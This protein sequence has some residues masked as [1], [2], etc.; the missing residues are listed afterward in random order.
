MISRMELGGGARMP[1][2]TWAAAAE[3]VDLRLVVDLVDARPDVLPRDGSLAVRC[4]RTIAREARIG[5]WTA[6]TEI[7]SQV[8]HQAIE[9]V[10]TRKSGSVVVVHAWDVVTRVA[11]SLEVLRSSVARERTGSDGIAVGGLIVVPS[12]PGNRRRM[13]EEHAILERETPALAAHWYAAIRNAHRPMPTDLGV[14]W[15]DRQG[16]RLVPAP[17]LPGWIWITPDHASRIVW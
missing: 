8:G 15:L 13:T 4:H 14:L 16:G 17:L 2:A 3:A 9:T 12:T 7:R 1:L 6:E 10:L 5:E 11:A